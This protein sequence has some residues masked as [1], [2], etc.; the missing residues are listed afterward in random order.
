MHIYNNQY[1]N[2][3]DYD[4]NN[5]TARRYYNSGVATNAPA[6]GNFARIAGRIAQG[7]ARSTEN[8]NSFHWLPGQGKKVAEPN[9]DTTRQTILCIDDKK[10]LD[11]VSMILKTHGGIKSDNPIEYVIT[12]YVPEKFRAELYQHLAK[13]DPY[14]RRI[15]MEK[16]PP[17]T[18][19]ILAR[20]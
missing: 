9:A 18:G 1:Q 14:F 12:T 10:A 3:L 15:C 8:V 20:N 16:Y 19:Q 6:S 4:F 7:I 11:S 13:I 17:K 2:R 5:D